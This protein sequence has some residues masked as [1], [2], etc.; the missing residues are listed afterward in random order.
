MFVT[1]RDGTTE[2]VKFDGEALPGVVT[3]KSMQSRAQPLFFRRPPDRDSFYG[4]QDLPDLAV[5]EGNWK[6]LC[7]YDGSAASLYN[8]ATD[9]A[10]KENLASGQGEVVKRLTGK[11]LAWH[12]QMPPDNG[13]TY[14]KPVRK[15]PAGTRK[16]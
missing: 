15:K 2:K 4:V 12:K 6:L 13:A 3:G 5:R 8:L 9:P 10:E 16:K 14:Q 11:V 1:K 7:E